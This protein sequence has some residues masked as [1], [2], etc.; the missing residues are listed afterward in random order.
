MDHLG[1]GI[2]QV[3]TMLGNTNTAANAV[4][5]QCDAGVAATNLFTAANTCT[6]N[7]GAETAY[8]ATLADVSQSFEDVSSSLAGLVDSTDSF[9]GM[10]SDFDSFLTD[11]EDRVTQATLALLSLGVIC[12]ILNFTVL[13]FSNLSTDG[14]GCCGC[15]G[16]LFGYITGPMTVIVLFIIFVILGLCMAISTFASDFCMD[17]D[18]HALDLVPFSTDTTAVNDNYNM[19]EFYT[20][21][22]GTDILGDYIDDSLSFIG[23]ARTELTS[24]KNACDAAS[25]TSATAVTCQTYYDDMTTILNEM[26]LAA[27]GMAASVECSEINPI[28]Q[29]FVYDALCDSGVNALVLLWVGLLVSGV[30]LFLTFGCYKSVA[31]SDAYKITKDKKKGSKEAIEMKQQV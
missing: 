13:V 12:A 17:P 6:N 10:T 9:V 15:M 19:I 16:G 29:S 8:D 27:N 11:Y 20:T 7:A 21:C 18:G 1:T 31:S 22:D 24:F 14:K 2:N 25:C 4:I 3:D 30:F 26:E 5:T 23:E 28:Y